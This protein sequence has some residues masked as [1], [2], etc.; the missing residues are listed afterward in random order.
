[1]AELYTAMLIDWEIDS[2]FGTHRL[3]GTIAGEDIKG[4][5]QSGDKIVTS[6]LKRIN[7]ETMMASTRSGSIYKLV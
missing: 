6:P 5:Y 3:I 4:R 1:M 2:S 7:F